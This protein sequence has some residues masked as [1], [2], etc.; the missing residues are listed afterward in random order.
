VLA[1]MAGFAVLGARERTILT[2][3]AD[4]LPSMAGRPGVVSAGSAHVPRAQRVDAAAPL[5]DLSPLSYQ[6][7][8]PILHPGATGSIRLRLDVVGDVPEVV[9]RRNVPTTATG[10]VEELWSR[11]TTRTVAGRLV[12]VFEQTYPGTILSDLLVYP[13]GHDFPQVPLGRLDDPG[14]SG[15]PATMWLRIASTGLPES[16]VRLITPLEGGTATAQYASHAVNLVLPGFNDAR[17]DGDGYALEAAAQ[18]FYRD[19]A[20]RYQS[21]AFVPHR[22]PLAPFDTFNRTVWSDL[23][24]IGMPL[25]DDRAA[26]GGTA[27]RAVQVLPA[28][29]LGHQA[30]LL[31]QLAHHWG[32]RMNLGTMAGIAPAGNDP[33]R[34]TPLLYPGATLV[35][36][37]LDGTR[38]V[39]RVVTGDG[40]ERFEIAR[41]AAP[42][43]FHPLQLYRM[44]FLDPADVPDVTVFAEQAQFKPQ[45]VSAPPV[46]T[47]VAGERRAVSINAILA[48]FGTRDGPVFTEWNQAVVIVSDTLLSQEEMDYYNFYAQRAAASTGTRAYDGFGSFFEAT[49]GRASLQTAILTRD[50]DAHPA[51]TQAGDVGDVAFGTGDW[52]GLMFDEP[53]PGRLPT[54]T[55]LTLRGNIDP[56]VLPG[57]YQFLI[58]RAS[59]FGDSPGDAMTVQTSVSGGRFVISLR[60]PADGAGAY[61]IDAF[62]FVDREATPIPTS[63][64]T[65]LFVD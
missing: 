19:F 42:V 37:V 53:I 31:H 32:D 63:V 30:T 38:R 46:G 22:M 12:S 7:F 44:G 35:G 3:A 6:Q 4:R 59:R 29:F 47:A 23:E 55:T 58:I 28:G 39:E 11:L 50:P 33:D 41:P 56:E 25:A 5:S 15:E 21:L 13:H 20:D 1:I 52:R 8:P 43:R 60:F 54:S 45:R 16:T 17:I 24:G 36:G 2:P 26:F 10:S 27:L 14:G 18:A 40:V 64:V 48:A 49:G 65:P 62:V 9:F 51:V 61:A 57:S 34:H